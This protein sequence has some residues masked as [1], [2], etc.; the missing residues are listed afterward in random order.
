M[1]FSTEELFLRV[2]AQAGER[3]KSDRTLMDEYWGALKKARQRALVDELVQVQNH[4]LLRDFPQLEW[5]IAG[6]ETKTDPM[7]LTVAHARSRAR[8]KKT[9][10]SITAFEVILKT[11]W[12]ITR[13]YGPPMPIPGGIRGPTPVGPSGVG[14]GMGMGTGPLPGGGRGH[15][16]TRPREST[17]SK[18]RPTQLV[19][20]EGGGN[21]SKKSKNKKENESRK[22]AEEHKNRQ[23]TSQSRVHVELRE[24]GAAGASDGGHRHSSPP[25][26]GNSHQ[27]PLIPPLQ[28]PPPPRPA[29][30]FVPSDGGRRRVHIPPVPP[31]ARPPPPQPTHIHMSSAQRQRAEEEEEEEAEEVF[32][33]IF[34]EFSELADPKGKKK[35]RGPGAAIS[36]SENRRSKKGNGKH[37]GDAEP[38]ASIS[39]SLMRQVEQASRRR[40]TAEGEELHNKSV[41]LE[42]M[43]EGQAPPPPPPPPPPPFVVPVPAESKRRARKRESRAG[44]VIERPQM[45]VE[46]ARKKRL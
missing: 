24:P 26:Q 32:K 40:L 2:L 7:A 43:A 27:P 25:G 30:G 23:Q 36:V 41:R 35:R 16:Q 44:R 6:L 28:P 38:D 1:P 20:V 5:T 4:H 13:G 21:R 3:A 9:R 42:Q 45:E 11:Q 10:K 15:S 34:E 19:L 8:G 31:G 39:M 33:Q 37:P 14:M 12:R 46:R 29:S 17:R 22:D 18:H